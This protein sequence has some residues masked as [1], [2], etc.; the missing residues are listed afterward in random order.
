VSPLF[1]QAGDQA[2]R[3]D[4]LAEEAVRCEP[5]SRANSLLTGKLTGNFEKFGPSAPIPHSIDQQ[6]QRLAAKF[7]TQR[8]REFS[9][10]IRDFVAGKQ[11]NFPRN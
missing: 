5:V 10:R 7:P 11:G 6:I 8:N 2:L 1:I 3:P 4:W 9:S